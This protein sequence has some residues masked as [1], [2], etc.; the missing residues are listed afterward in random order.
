VSSP[1][2]VLKENYELQLMTVF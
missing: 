1:V 2:M